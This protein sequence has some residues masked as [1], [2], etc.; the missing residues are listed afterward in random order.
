[1]NKRIYIS[2]VPAVLLK[3]LDQE[4]HAFTPDEMM[5][6][7]AIKRSDND[8][9]DADIGEIS[10]YLSQYSPAQL[11]GISN[12]VKGIYHE[13]RFVEAENTDGDD[14]EAEL[15]ELTNHP[16]ADV[17]LI[18]TATG[19]VTDLQLK[20]AN[21]V[22]YVGEHLNRYPDI[23]VLA[24]EE[25]SNNLSGVG[26][27]G[28]SN[29]ELTNDVSGTLNDLT[30]S[31]NYIESAATSGLLSAVLNTK[32]ALEG[33]QSG[34]AATRRTLEDLGIAGVSAAIIELLVG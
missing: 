22:H 31:S 33:K 15:Y 1:M 6:I 34:S 30:E 9:V 27:S 4:S 17:R 10:S 16:G 5:V 11:Q 18:N 13:I 8:L 12:N 25:V 28:F 23:D 7:E 20:A 19:E 24:T 29:D 32:A 26:A 14:I 3:L 2:I 21:S